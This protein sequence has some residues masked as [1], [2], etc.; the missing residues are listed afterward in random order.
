MKLL[1]I[2][3]SI[4]GLGILSSCKKSGY[5]TKNGGIYYRDYLMR[6]ADYDSFQELND[7]FARD[8]TWGYYRGVTLESSDGASF[9][10]L[11]EHYAKDKATVY[12]CDNYIDFKLFETS[13]KDK[14]SRVSIADAGSFTV[15]INEYA[16]DKFRC[17]YQG[18]GFAVKDIAS[19]EPLNYGF[20]K[21]KHVG[22]FE[23]K[24]IPGSKGSSFSVLNRN[25]SKDDQQLND[26][27]LE[28]HRFEDEWNS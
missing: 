13:R 16:K 23:L 6:T 19:F 2:L 8:K 20:G 17:Y 3:L 24:A 1:H 14:I 7:V 9:A 27:G 22:Y 4:L 15:L 11:D 5:Q 25:F 28:V 10:A 18:K 21:D 26:Y 12:Y